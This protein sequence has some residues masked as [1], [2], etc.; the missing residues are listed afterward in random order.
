[1]RL[2][3]EK[4][5]KQLHFWI[6]TSTVLISGLL[7]GMLLPVIAIIFEQQGLPSS[8]NGFH[9]TGMYIGVLLISPFI[10]KPLITYGY[11]KMAV[12]GIIIVLLS[13]LSFTFISSVWV[14]FVL[15]LLI[16][17]GDHMLHFST[18][19]WLM[20]SSTKS[21][22][23][24]RIAIYGIFFGLGFALGP[25]FV[26]LMSFHTYAPFYLAALLT[27]ISLASVF[28]LHNQYP[29]RSEQGEGF[30]GS[31]KRM[32]EVMSFAWIALIPA[33]IYGFLEASLHGN[34]PVFAL[35]ENI[36]ISNVAIILPAFALGGIITQL[37]IGELSD[38]FGRKKVLKII[39]L[40]GSIV[41]F[42][43]TIGGTS[44]V[45]MISIFLVSGMIVGS[46][47]SLGMSYMADLLPAYL[48]PAG[49]LMCGIFYS[50]GSMIGPSIGGIYLEVVPSGSF[51][52][53]PSMMLATCFV[54]FTFHG[55]KKFQFN[56]E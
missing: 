17:I 11:K 37:P 2:R 21:N 16:G 31:L 48:L 7:Q 23:G 14:W 53:L 46:A 5:L 44:F 49:N 28:I 3:E 47:F 36:S 22:R 6:L 9:V 29:E 34:F 33:L 4:L 39:F 56:I 35:R 52:V 12:T 25:L 13:L 8:I 50:L 42:I 40:L 43:G 24:K 38:R 54:I 19:T 32:K 30:I 15:R 51:F 18:Q 10:E 27:C 55:R 26:N 1:M 20:A 45:W 41:F